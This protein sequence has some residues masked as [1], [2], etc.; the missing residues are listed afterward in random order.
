MI[1]PLIIRILV[2]CILL[3]LG[4]TTPASSESW[5]FTFPPEPP[6]ERYGNILINRSP[7]VKPVGFSHWSHRIKFTCRVCHTELGFSLKTNTTEITEVANRNGMY[8]GA[9]HNGKTTFD[10]TEENCDKC[11]NDDI[12]Y[13]REKFSGLSFLPGTSYGNRIDWVRALEDGLIMPNTCLWDDA[14]PIEYEG[15]EPKGKMTILPKW[16][17]IKA[18]AEFSHEIHGKWLDCSNCH[19]DIFNERVNT[20]KDFMMINNL[21]G[22]FCGTCHGKVSFPFQACRKCHPKLKR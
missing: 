2:I 10:Y 11:H 5:Y 9:C 4:I 21:K 17:Y 16:W 3:S 1:K 20:T 15:D 22:L 18:T 13:N 14:A 12:D 19:P 7:D 6:P 8:C